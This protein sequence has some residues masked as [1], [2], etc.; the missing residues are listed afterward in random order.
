LSIQNK[1]RN[2]ASNLFARELR[3]SAVESDNKLKQKKIKEKKHKAKSTSS[4]K[5]INSTEQ[6]TA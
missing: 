3:F 5:T 4:L 6:R 2:S 1:L